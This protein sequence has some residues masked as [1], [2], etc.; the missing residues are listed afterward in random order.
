MYSICASTSEHSVVVVRS[1]PVG[2]L[3]KVD[4][5]AELGLTEILVTTD[6]ERPLS[7]EQLQRLAAEQG[8]V[9]A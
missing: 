9:A 3:A 8:A 2:A 7:R 6:S 4:E 5:F 1:D